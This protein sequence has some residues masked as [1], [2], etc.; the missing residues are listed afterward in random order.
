[1]SEKV[2]YQ[3][4]LG[5]QQR[6]LLSAL[7]NG[8]REIERVLV[9]KWIHGRQLVSSEVDGIPLSVLSVPFKKRLRSLGWRIVQ[10]GHSDDGGYALRIRLV[11]IECPEED[12]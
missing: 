8:E 12:K 10:S 2:Y 1:M 4:A 3:A 5:T 7:E 6:A 11:E 9:P